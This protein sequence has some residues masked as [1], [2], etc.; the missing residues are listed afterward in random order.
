MLSGDPTRRT[1]RWPIGLGTQAELAERATQWTCLRYNTAGATGYDDN[2]AGFP[3][4]DCEAGFQ[5]R[6]GPPLG[7]H[8][9]MSLPSHV[10][11]VG[12]SGRDMCACR[13][14]MSSVPACWDG[15]NLD[16]PNHSSHVRPSSASAR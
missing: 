13:L 3:T 1:K 16:S 15:V 4:T 6:M 8:E 2:G 11:I 12:L 5:V 14:M 9:L 10:F 7:Y